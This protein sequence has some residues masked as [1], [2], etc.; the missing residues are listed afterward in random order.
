MFLFSA[1]NGKDVNPIYRMLDIA[2]T[3][4]HP[5]IPV[6]YSA[7]KLS[8]LCLIP[9]DISVEWNDSEITLSLSA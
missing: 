7:L 6:I 1:S 8:A 4:S 3:M 5:F 2:W 9:L